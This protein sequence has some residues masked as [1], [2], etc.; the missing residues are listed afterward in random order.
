MTNSDAQN[1]CSQYKGRIASINVRSHWWILATNTIDS[2]NPKDKNLVGTMPF[3]VNN[4]PKGFFKNLV[5]VMANEN[6]L[7]PVQNHAVVANYYKDLDIVPPQLN[8]VTGNEELEFWCEFAS[9]RL[10]QRTLSS[11]SNLA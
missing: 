6:E 3:Y 7:Q 8:V 9:Y 4:N 1:Y 5:M 11:F 2:A 10:N